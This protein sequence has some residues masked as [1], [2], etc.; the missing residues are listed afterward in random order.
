MAVK[1][2]LADRGKEILIYNIRKVIQKKI[3]DY[4]MENKWSSGLNS[5]ARI[6]K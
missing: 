3:K 2:E 1:K 5:T 4:F 6:E